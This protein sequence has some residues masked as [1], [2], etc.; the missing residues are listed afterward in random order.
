VGGKGN[1]PLFDCEPKKG[2]KKKR[3]GAMK[4]VGGVEGEILRK[5]S[6][7]T[8]GSRGGRLRIKG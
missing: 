7:P 3:A 1:G 8:R 4:N 5:R 6:G 2:G